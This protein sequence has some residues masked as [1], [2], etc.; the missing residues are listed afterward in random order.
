MGEHL[1]YSASQLDR[2]LKCSASVAFKDFLVETGQIKEEESNPYAEEG[3]LLHSV[4][5][6]VM[7][8]GLDID[9]VKALTPEQKALVEWAYYEWL[10]FGSECGFVVEKS[11]DVSFRD[12]TGN[13]PGL[14]DV[15][16]TADV[17]A[18]SLVSSSERHIVDWKFGFHEVSAERNV[19][20][21]TYAL[22]L[23]YGPVILHIIQPKLE[24]HSVW[25]AEQEDL[26]ELYNQIV[27]MLEN[28]K[29][30]KAGSHCK[31]C[32]C[33]TFCENY[34][35]YSE[36]KTQQ[37]FAGLSSQGT[38][39]LSL[40][41]TVDL[42]TQFKKQLRL[43]QH[44]KQVKGIFR[45]IRDQLQQ[46]TPGQL[47]EVGFKRVLGRATRKITD[48]DAL[49]THLLHKGFDPDLI[50]TSVMKSPAQLEKAIPGLKRDPVFKELV[51]KFYGAPIIVP[52]E[53]KR[54]SVDQL[55]EK[56]FENYRK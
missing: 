9:E 13:H 35:Q 24:K 28:P 44:E 33:K 7:A 12:I 3:T 34:T 51:Q 48:P 16:G 8:H 29:T 10:S 30:F 39:D 46:L 55:A 37:V 49:A 21:M 56:A 47:S 14:K 43:L 6:R 5:E 18:Y 27:H 36:H 31:W 11:S 15:G 50:F 1:K 17:F 41:P 45:A 19:Q 25:V 23:T 54:P 40:T 20:L 2:I 52:V 42:M 32:Q 22:G 38:K 4:M 53:D 26:T